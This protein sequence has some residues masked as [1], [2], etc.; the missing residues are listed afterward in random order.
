MEKIY[1]LEQT[2]DEVPGDDGWLDSFELQ[3]Q[4]GLR[5]PKRRADWRLG[6]WTAKNAV[7]ARLALQSEGAAC[8]SI[9]IRAAPDGAP[10]A[11]VYGR[12]SEWSI[13]LSHS[14]GTAI[15]AVASSA[16]RVGCDLD[17]I[18][19]RGEAFI[20]DYFT[21]SE[22]LLFR[23]APPDQADRTATILWSAKESAL[24]A[25]RQGLRL[26][27]RSVAVRLIE[28]RMFG[29]WSGLEICSDREATFYGWWSV[30]GELVRT[31][32]AE[33]IPAV[34]VRLPVRNEAHLS[35]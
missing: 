5:F 33:A 23:E 28:N 26:D 14:A 16:C 9:S 22:K 21:A 25:L 27:T 15:C 17:S 35:L 6:R 20:D 24:K 31:I 8:G 11:F 34:P 18:E 3:V 13:S 2:A 7:A 1:W 10:E 29:P 4:R 12:P 32:V 19:P 30:T